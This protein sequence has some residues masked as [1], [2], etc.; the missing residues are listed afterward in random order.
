M[1]TPGE[2][3]QKACLFMEQD[4]LD[5]A[6]D[7]FLKLL[8][9]TSPRVPGRFFTSLSGFL[10]Q[11]VVSPADSTQWNLDIYLA[12]KLNLARIFWQQ[13]H[14]SKALRCLNEILY[15]SPSAEIYHLQSRWLLKLGR[16]PEAILA[17]SQAIQ[18][19]SIYL[20]A[21]EDLATIAN[22]NGDPDL[23]YQIIQKG[24]IHHLTPRLLE[25]L[26]LASGKNE[27]I[28]MRSL[29]L[30]L[31][32]QNIKPETHDLLLPLLEN[33]Y[34]EQDYHHS[35]YLGFHLLHVFQHSLEILNIYVLSA[36]H[37]K[38]FAPA[39]QALL[40]APET[41]QEQG[42]YWFKL[43][44]VYSQWNMP[45]FSRFSFR[46]ALKIEPLMD[47]QARPYLRN[48]PNQ[49]SSDQILT[50]ILRQ[51]MVSEVFCQSIKTMP[52][53]TLKKW[54]ISSSPELLTGLKKSFPD[55][56]ET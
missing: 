42:S 5:A 3:F 53:E 1:S 25:E 24:M 41:F 47:T 26:I 38:H 36:L 39:L 8:Q 30:E 55:K 46:K 31:C 49:Y 48:L 22:Q 12:S 44:I 21:Y 52:L 50:E 13:E 54:G 17:L 37:Q 23:A 10:E 15:Q 40:N 29:F 34:T 7:L 14:T 4:N 6:Q 27:Y 45:L 35:E 51:A 28:S 56:K 43:G 18:M 20:A 16:S 2:D 9:N 19:D 32:V 33:L 11:A